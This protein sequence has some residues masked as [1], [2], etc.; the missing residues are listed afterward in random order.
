M[1]AQPHKRDIK[2]ARAAETRSGPAEGGGWSDAA[3]PI[4][5]VVGQRSD[6]ADRERTP[7]NAQQQH[8]ARA[9]DKSAVGKVRND[10]SNGRFS[11]PFSCSWGSCAGSCVFCGRGVKISSPSRGGSFDP[12]CAMCCCAHM[13]SRGTPGSW[14]KNDIKIVDPPFAR[15]IAARRRFARRSP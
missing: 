10:G 5:D 9:L 4:E 8:G 2:A 15:G 13:N 3:K 12:I 11:S 7:E 14:Y 6:N 1:P